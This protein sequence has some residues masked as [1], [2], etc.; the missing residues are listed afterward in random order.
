MG[1]SA[2]HVKEPGRTRVTM[3]DVAREARVS[4][5]LVS[6]VMRDSPKV[7]EERRQR[8]VAAAKRLATA[9]TPWR[10]DWRAAGR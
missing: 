10:G 2:K 8:V 1:P 4:R 5:A 7:S 6:L 9:R 3:D